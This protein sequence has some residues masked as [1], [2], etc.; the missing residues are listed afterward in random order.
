MKLFLLALVVAGTLSV[1]ATTTYFVLDGERYA[2][3]VPVQTGDSLVSITGGVDR[4]SQYTFTPGPKNIPF[5]ANKGGCATNLEQKLLKQME[6]VKGRRVLIGYSLGGLFAL[7]FY[8]RHPDLKCKIIALDPSLWWKPTLLEQKFD[9]KNMYVGFAMAKQKTRL[10]EYQR[11][12]AVAFIKK[13]PAMSES[14]ELATHPTLFE[15][16]ITNALE[17]IGRLDAE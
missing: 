13:Y 11:P 8:L 10:F 1:V 6:Q 3:L 17:R 4:L 9:E 12:L 14:Y 15:M 2:N 7:E 5:F 16:A